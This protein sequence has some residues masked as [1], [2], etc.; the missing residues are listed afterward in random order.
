M[1]THYDTHHEAFERRLAVRES[2]PPAEPRHVVCGAVFLFL[3]LVGLATSAHV[4]AN[5]LLPVDAMY[6]SPVGF[7]P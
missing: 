1:A 2:L 6:A 5:R 4:V 7:G 3:F